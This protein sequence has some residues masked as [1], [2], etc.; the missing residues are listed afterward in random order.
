MCPW[1]IKLSYFVL[2]AHM[3]IKISVTWNNQRPTSFTFFLMLMI[4]FCFSEKNQEKCD[5]RQYMH[6]LASFGAKNWEGMKT[7]EE[8]PEGTNFPRCCSFEWKICWQLIFLECNSAKENRFSSTF[9]Y[10]ENGLEGQI[11]ARNLYCVLLGKQPFTLEL[12]LLSRRNWSFLGNCFWKAKMQGL[13]NSIRFLFSA[14]WF[15]IYLHLTVLSCN[16]M[17]DCNH[18]EKL[19]LM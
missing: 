2:H 9:S 3:T 14:S 8:L 19:P 12:L 15:Q 17:A 7:L 4:G 5:I 1:R 18:N 10:K 16:S 13:A 11:F 6:S